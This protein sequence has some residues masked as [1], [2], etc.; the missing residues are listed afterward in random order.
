MIADVGAPSK[1][2]LKKEILNFKYRSVNITAMMAEQIAA[3]LFLKAP[4]ASW[5]YYTSFLDMSARR[6]MY[7]YE[8]LPS[9]LPDLRLA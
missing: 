6:D 2:T 7:R 4:L 3:K 8:S 1:Q 9:M 5:H